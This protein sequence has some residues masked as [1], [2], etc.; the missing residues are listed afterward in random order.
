MKHP[1]DFRRIDVRPAAQDK[2]R[3]SVGDVEPAFLIDAAM[4]TGVD[5]AIL[6]QRG[7]LFR[8]APLAKRRCIDICPWSAFCRTKAYFANFAD[9]Q[10]LALRIADRQFEVGQG[11]AARSRRWRFLAR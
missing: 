7:G 3:A 2:F 8:F 9:G 5:N 10:N 11:D 1:F 6:E 4:V